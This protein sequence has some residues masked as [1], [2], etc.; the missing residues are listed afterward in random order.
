MVTVK[1]KR[2]PRRWQSYSAIIALNTLPSTRQPMSSISVAVG[3]TFNAALLS[4]AVA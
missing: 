3:R 4:N 1:M 2:S